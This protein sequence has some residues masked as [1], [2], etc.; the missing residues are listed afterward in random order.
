MKKTSK[1]IIAFV[2]A[3]TIASTVLVVAIFQKE[4]AD[5]KDPTVLYTLQPSTISSTIP[6]TESFVDINAIANDLAS[7][8]DA[9]VTLTTLPGVVSTNAQG[10]QYVFVDQYGNIVDPNNLNGNVI[11][12][13]VPVEES[14]EGASGEF[15]EP[16]KTEETKMAN[17]EV[18]NNGKI[19]KYF[20]NNDA[21]MV[22]KTI[23][24]K[25]V[26]GVADGCF[27]DSTISSVYFSGSIKSIGNNAFENCQYLKTVMFSTT[28]ELSIGTNVFKGCV[29]LS[30]IK[31]P[32]VT[33]MGKS[34]FD[35]CT[36]LDNVTFADGTTQI[37]DY[38]FSNCKALTMVT[39]PSTVTEENLGN[40]IFF[41]CNTTNLTVVTPSA[42]A[43][44]DYATAVGCNCRNP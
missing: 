26:T 29:A 25:T 37:G 30:S 18:D 24:G 33:T 40:K 39:I 36:S 10:I 43:A 15:V 23:N 6:V 42:S 19:V 9:A 8:T 3:L 7:D 41:E 31:L 4:G 44:W 32:A 28:D 11:A 2:V 35:G 1:I 13:S 16:D 17:F 38:C 12:G 21:V 22:P 27:K 34:A 14:M 5:S 20:G